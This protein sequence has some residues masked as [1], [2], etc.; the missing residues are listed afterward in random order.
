[1]TPRT[2]L[3]ALLVALVAAPAA[4]ALAAPLPAYTCIDGT[5]QFVTPTGREVR[6]PEV[7]VP[8]P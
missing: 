5:R 1:M 8:T 2:A 7:C 3:A 4:T 6:T